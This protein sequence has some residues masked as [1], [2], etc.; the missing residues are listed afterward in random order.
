MRSLP[1]KAKLS[2]EVS[3]ELWRRLAAGDRVVVIAAELGVSRSWVSTVRRQAGGVF[4]PIKDYSGR[5]LSEVERWEIA[6]LVEA[7]HGVREVAVLMGRSASTISRELR[8]NLDPRLQRYV[9]GRAQQMAQLRQR[10]PK[11]RK[12][13]R[14]PRLRAEVQRGLDDRWSPEQI[15]GRLKL[16]FSDDD[17]M[18]VSPETIYKCIYI[19]PVGEMERLL[20][21]SLRSKRGVR[22][23]HGRRTRQG[24]IPDLVS[25][26]DRPGEVEERQVPGHHEGDLIVG[27]AVTNSAI[28]TVV[29]RVTGYTTLVHLPEGRSSEHVVAQVSAAMSTLPAVFAKSLTWDR[30]KEMTAHTKLTSSTGLSVYFADPYSPWQRGTNENTNGLLREYFPKGT[31]LSQHSAVDLQA[32]QDQLNNRPRKRLGFHTPLEEFTRLIA[33]DTGVATTP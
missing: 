17:D 23:P 10:R 8:R 12:L 28:A 30:G 5:Y 1:R 16:D 22:R 32:V 19:K 3:R 20:S 24:Q 9:P 2:R 18:R 11:Q 33:Q 31:D 29:E 4:E 15:S 7:G 6:R 27:A 14:F 26:H 21:A 25:I 13:V